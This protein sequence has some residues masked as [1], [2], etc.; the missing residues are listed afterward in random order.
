MFPRPKIPFLSQSWLNID[1]FEDILVKL[2]KVK[3]ICRMFL[4]VDDHP[5]NYILSTTWQTIEGNKFIFF[6]LV[7]DLQK[8]GLANESKIFGF[9]EIYLALRYSSWRNRTIRLIN[10]ID[11][12]V[13]PVIKC[14]Q[15][16]S[17]LLISKNQNILVSESSQSSAYLCISS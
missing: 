4:L 8:V 7:K 12:S 11:F 14:L 15:T 3:N 9:Q 1:A 13:I 5:T 6:S 10:C 2:I 17:S 16:T